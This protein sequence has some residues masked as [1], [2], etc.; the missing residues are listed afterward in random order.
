MHQIC[1]SAA[2]TKASSR[3]SDANLG[4]TVNKWLVHQGS[5]CSVLECSGYMF[6]CSANLADVSKRQ[7]RR[8]EVEYFECGNL[9][10]IGSFHKWKCVSIIHPIVSNFNIDLSF[11]GQSDSQYLNF[12]V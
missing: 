9:E 11:F 7:T 3:Q 1:P 8:Q 4:T 12:Y 6:D 10:V 2:N 5:P